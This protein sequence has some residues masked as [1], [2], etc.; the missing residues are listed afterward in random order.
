MNDGKSVISKHLPV[1][2]INYDNIETTTFVK[3][4]P[5]KTTIEDLSTIIK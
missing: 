5:K 1:E 4:D 2:S 3:V